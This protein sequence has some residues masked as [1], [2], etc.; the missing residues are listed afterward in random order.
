MA[1][2]N[3]WNKSDLSQWKIFFTIGFLYL[4]F[5]L[6]RIMTYYVAAGIKEI[7]YFRFHSVERPF[8]FA[9]FWEILIGGGNKK[10]T[11]L[12]IQEK[13]SCC[14]WEVLLVIIRGSCVKSLS[15][16]K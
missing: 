2:W 4:D 7:V 1:T 10:F 16:E 9:F 6:L 5:V 14:K 11:T 13:R 8:L 15:S 3:K 12:A